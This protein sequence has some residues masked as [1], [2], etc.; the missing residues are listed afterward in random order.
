MR[1]F[2]SRG[3]STLNP[4]LAVNLIPRSGFTLCNKYEYVHPRIAEQDLVKI[5]HLT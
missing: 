4:D 2:I 5:I 3:P 1:R